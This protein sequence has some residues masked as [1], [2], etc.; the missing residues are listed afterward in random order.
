MLKKLK[1]VSK[2]PA[3]PLVLK[4]I[5]LSGFLVWIKF[6]DGSRLIHVFLFVS[7]ALFFYLQPLINFRKLLFSFLVFLTLFL[8]FVFQQTAPLSHPIFSI[9]VVFGLSAAFYLILGIKNLIFVDRRSFYFLLNNL[10]LFLIFLFFFSAESHFSLLNYFLFFAAVFLITGEFLRFLIA[11]QSSQQRL[12]FSAF[13]AFLAL[14]FVWVITFLP[15][16]FLNSAALA[17]FFVF[18]LGD[19]V[20]HHLSGTLNRFLILRDIT[21]LIVITIL[22]FAASRWSL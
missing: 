3:L 18:V 1:S 5:V 17:L 22:V 16:G 14:Q 6:G 4:T 2:A 9:M 15:V 7:L 8:F 12:L 13:F 10:L 20:I 19:F 21:I 11:G